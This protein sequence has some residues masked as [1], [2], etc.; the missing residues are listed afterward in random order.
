[1]PAVSATRSATLLR[2]HLT[3]LQGKQGV[4]VMRDQRTF[5]GTVAEFDDDW[6][7]LRDVL[8]GT[9]VNSRGWE[10]TTI[11]TGFVEKHLG[12]GGVV[13]AA[14]GPVQLVRL[15]DVLI[16]VDGVLRIWP[17]VPENL[18]KPEHVH[19]DARSTVF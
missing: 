2:K 6:V 12:R 10:E 3:S 8:E 1:M 17:W 14:K 13:S 19:M 18:T 16:N 5:K 7:L 11:S 15:K 9:T 4:V